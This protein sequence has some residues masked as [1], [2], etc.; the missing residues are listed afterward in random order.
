MDYDPL[1]GKG[2]GQLPD[3][4]P[5]WADYWKARGRAPR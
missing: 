1:A 4:W 3:A 2:D 5:S